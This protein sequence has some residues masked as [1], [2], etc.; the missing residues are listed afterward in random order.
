MENLGTE[1]VQRL[2]GGSYKKY[3][4]NINWLP[5]RRAPANIE[6]F[7]KKSIQENLGISEM[8]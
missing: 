2:E 3:T 6:H 4:C 7:L 8:K 5:E 1:V